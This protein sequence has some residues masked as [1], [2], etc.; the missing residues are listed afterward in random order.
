MITT[1]NASNNDT[2]FVH[3]RVRLH[4]DYGIPFDEIQN[5]VRY[6]IKPARFM[7]Q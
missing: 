1:D 6:A 3:M 2:M 7:Q 5:H 4:T